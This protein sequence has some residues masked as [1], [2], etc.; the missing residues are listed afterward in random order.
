M[1]RVGVANLS[2]ADD[3]VDLEIALRTD[4]W[5]YTDSLV[6]ELH[7]KAI[8]IGLRINGHR[9]D[10]KFSAGPNDAK[11]DFA[12]IGDQ[13]FFKHGGVAVELLEAEERLTKL[14]GLAIFGT[15]FRNDTR[16]LSLDL[17][18]DFHGFDNA[19]N[20]IWRHLLADREE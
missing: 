11:S 14:H 10:A 17:V 18:H 8:D 20:G 19:D 1:N 5:P 9:L 6:S 3:A 12:A 4:G 7:M 2:G 13:N 16:D 15:D